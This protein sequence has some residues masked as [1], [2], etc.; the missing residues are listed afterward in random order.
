MALQAI[1]RVVTGLDGEGRS[2]VII[3]DCLADMAGRGQ[4]VWRTAAV[5]AD[6]S[7]TGDAAAGSLTVES[8]HDPGSL[9]MVIEFAP[10]MGADPFWHA[11]DT[12]DYIVMMEG[13]VD[14]ATETGKVTLGAGD[15]LVDRGTVHSWSNPHASRALATFAIIPALPVGKGRT[16]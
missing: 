16:V 1:R 9:F 3:D 5:P 12:I 6:N 13:E 11:T 4:A 7:G 2:A 8:L 15:V 10:G 14:F